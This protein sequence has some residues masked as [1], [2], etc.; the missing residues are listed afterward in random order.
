MGCG[1]SHLPRDQNLIY[2]IL[3]LVVS[4]DDYG[5][6]SYEISNKTTLCHILHAPHMFLPSHEMDV[7]QILL[8]VRH[9]NMLTST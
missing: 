9:F 4:T 2:H 3:A 8:L 7:C 1:L 6:T 5:Y